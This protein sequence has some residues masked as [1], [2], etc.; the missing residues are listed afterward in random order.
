MYQPASNR[1]MSDDST[2]DATG[3]AYDRFDP[4]AAER[5][6]S[7]KSETE[8]VDLTGALHLEETRARVWYLEPGHDRKGTHVHE[9]QEELYYVIEGPG[10]LTV[11][12]ETLDVPEGAFVRLPPK[13]PRQ[14]FNDTDE[15]HV[16]LI[17]GAPPVTDDGQQLG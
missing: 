5:D 7:G 15:E 6:L 2:L 4:A 12:D 1:D 11:A 8:H 14:L 9:Q 10:Q 16:W 13:T 3:D 17:V